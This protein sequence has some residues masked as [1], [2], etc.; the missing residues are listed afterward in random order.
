MIL[1]VFLSDFS[2]YTRNLHLLASANFAARS[3]TIANAVLHS[4]QR[5]V[6]CVSRY[7]WL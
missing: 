4:D 1:S 2:T 3:T 5:A 7:R 6:P